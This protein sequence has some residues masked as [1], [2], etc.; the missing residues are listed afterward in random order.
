M[1]TRKK[2]KEGGVSKTEYF[3]NM[4]ENSQIIKPAK[5]VLRRREGIRKQ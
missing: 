2:V 4:C 1:G 5:I 3:I